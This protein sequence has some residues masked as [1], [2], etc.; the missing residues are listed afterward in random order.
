MSPDDKTAL[1]EAV[2]GR[3]AS[4]PVSV[5]PA[6]CSYRPDAVALSTYASVRLRRVDTCRPKVPR[7]A[8]AAAWLHEIKYDGFRVV[9]RNYTAE[10]FVPPTCP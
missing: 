3:P 4:L 1:Q 5:I 6:L 2:K 10:A 7:P 8:S 9:A